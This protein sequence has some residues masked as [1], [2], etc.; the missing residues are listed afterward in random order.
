MTTR[1]GNCARLQYIRTIEQTVYP[2]I[3]LDIAL[4]LISLIFT[5]SHGLAFQGLVECPQSWLSAGERE[6]PGWFCFSAANFSN[7][8]RGSLS[9]P[10]WY[11][12][13]Q[14]VP[15]IF[16]MA[17]FSTREMRRIG[18]SCSELDMAPTEE[19]SKHDSA[20]LLATL[21]A[22]CIND[23][24]NKRRSWRCLFCTTWHSMLRGERGHST[25]VS[26]TYGPCRKIHPFMPSAV[27][28]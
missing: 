16:Q 10:S 3:F 6:L 17:V 4:G 25:N 15:R 26:A 11:C 24:C 13:K 2:Y 27:A 12:S 18:I 21:A 9:I 23:A 28:A 1:T 20:A 5:S 22:I 7:S 14:C 19:R 8:C